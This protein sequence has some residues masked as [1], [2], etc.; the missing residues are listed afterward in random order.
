MHGVLGENG[1]GKS[2]L[3]GV[4]GGM[5]APD[6]GEVEVDGIRGRPRSPVEARKRGIGFVHQN[7]RLVERMTL[8]DNFALAS[9][10]PSLRLP[11]SQVTARVR[12]LMQ[13]TEWRLPLSS[14]VEDLSIGDRQRTEILK[15]LIAHPRILILDEPTAMLVPTEIRSLFALLRKLAGNG[16]AI[17]L[18]AHKLDEVMA[19]AD[20]FTVLRHGRT[21]LETAPSADVPGRVGRAELADAMVGHLGETGVAAGIEPVARVA[22]DDHTPEVPPAA[23]GDA[24]S[25]Q[26][27]GTGVSSRA[28]SLPAVASCRSVSVRGRT[29]EQALNGVSLEI[30]RGEIVGVVGV[31][32]NGQRELAQVMAGRLAPDSGELALPAEVGYIP[33]DRS[34]EGIAAG[35]DLVENIALHRQSVAGAVLRWGELRDETRSLIREFGVQTAN[36]RSAAGSLSGGNQQRLLAARELGREVDLIVAAN[37]TRGLDFRSTAFVHRTLERL[38]RGAVPPGVLLITTDLDEAAAL[39]H[40]AFALVRGRL[41]PTSGSEVGRGELGRLMVSGAG[42]PESEPMPSR[43]G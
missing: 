40:R 42:K 23:F 7:F 19:V 22:T 20:R 14:R 8:I 6:A 25:G 13:L 28:P 9:P 11:I 38:V 4:L 2:T 35:L 34:R 10:L 12:E 24:A 30:G 43:L 21:V 3:L 39:S 16:L 5:V 18:V 37:P 17:A 36:E 15:A 41:V 31:E 26:V 29:G 33:Q 27:S 1:A 32:G